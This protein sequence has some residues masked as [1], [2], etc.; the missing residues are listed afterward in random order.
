MQAKPGI[1][2]RPSAEAGK[3]SPA[4]IIVKNSANTAPVSTVSSETGLA[5]LFRMGV[6]NG[7]YAEIG[8]VRRRNLID[9]NRM[10][11]GQLIEIA[12]EFGLEAKPGHFDWQSLLATPFS[13]PLLLILDNSNA[14]VL[15]GMRRG[16][17]GPAAA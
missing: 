14:I 4:E 7:V 5:C 6:Q 15:L 3:A 9:G 2:G 16:A 10:P 8:A 13:H 1:T 11:V 12:G 17:A